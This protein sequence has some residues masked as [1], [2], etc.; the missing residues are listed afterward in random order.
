MIDVASTRAHFPA[1]ATDWALLDN[2]GGTAPARQV[3]ARVAEYM[4]RWPVQ[5]GASY[6]LSVEAVA[7]VAA[8]RAAAARLVGAATDEVVLG[9]SATVLLRRLAEALA[10]LWAPGDE[11]VVTDLDHEANVGPWRA[12]AAQGIVVREWG[13]SRAS[14]ALELADL[15]PL[16]SARTRLVAFTHCANVVG[17]IHDARAIV[18]RV[19]AAGALACVDGVAFAP[20]RRVD[21][22]ALGADFY[23]ASLYKLFGPHLGLLYGRRELLRAAR[24]VSHFF[25]PEDDVPR[26]FEPGGVPHELAAGL[27]GIL[28]CIA[29]L[30]GLPDAAALTAEGLDACFED[31][32]RREAE[33]ARPLLEFLASHPRVRLIGK[34]SADPRERVSTM[35]FTV[36]GLPSSA[37]VAQLETRRLAARWGHFYARRAM[38]PLGLDPDQGLVR[39]SLAHY[40]TP[41]EVARVI[42]ALEACV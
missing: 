37:V 31:S 5:H 19:H 36:D 39:V 14:E 34:A 20:H 13:L 41:E 7:R 30:R 23:A 18:A 10:P 40:N 11:V 6:P 16:L 28:D 3:I 2:A 15:E 24:G 42:E 29:A 8:G 9:P 1:L 17:T 26:K 33:L 4:A 22:R 21:V 35:A 32:A 25:V 27:P 38:G 12:L